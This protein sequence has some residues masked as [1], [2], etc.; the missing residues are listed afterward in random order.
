MRRWTLT[1]ALVLVTLLLLG[2]AMAGKDSG[3]E[4]IKGLEHID[5]K[6]DNT[7]GD[8][9]RIEYEVEVLEGKNINVYFMDAE[10]YDNYTAIENFTYYP[11]VSAL[12]T[13]S[14]ENEWTWTKKGNFYVVID[15]TEYQ[16]FGNSTVE[17]EVEWEAGT[18]ILG[19]NWI[20]FAVTIVIIVVL[21]VALWWMRNRDK[22]GKDEEPPEEEDEVDDIEPLGAPG[23]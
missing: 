14:A 16:E 4:T 2:T 12:D 19:F 15:I 18:Y 1:L 7:A 22:G 8:T 20:W 11:E 23:L 5:V 10:G 6:I 3:T 13:M 21:S 17:F 9:L